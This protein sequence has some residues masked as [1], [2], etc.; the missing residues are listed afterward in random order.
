MVTWGW[1]P[2]SFIIGTVFGMVLLA[3]MEVSREN[4]N[5]KGE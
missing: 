5:K 4:N 3:F 2:F 1:I